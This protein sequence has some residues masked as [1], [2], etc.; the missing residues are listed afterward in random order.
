MKLS[1][2]EYDEKSEQIN[3][4]IAILLGLISGILMGFL[5]SH[6]VDASYIFLGILI[7]NAIAFKIDGIH[8]VFSLISFIA[9]CLIYGLHS[10]SLITLSICIISAY[11]DEFGNDN[12]GLYEKSRF[13]MIF[14]DYRFSMKIAI[15]ILGILGVYGSLTGFSIKYI[16]FLS[17]STII[18]F[19]L[20]ELSYEFAGILFKMFI[21]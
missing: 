13:F 21:K 17:L 6:N 3:K 15:I 8:H 19:I 7:G 4:I 12:K 16:D 9:I 10:L 5:A 11:I 18:Y 1:D 14:F 2:D 20:F